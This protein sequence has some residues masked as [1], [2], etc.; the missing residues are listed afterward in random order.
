MALEIQ[1]FDGFNVRQTGFSSAEAV[2]I[3]I[4]LRFKPLDVVSSRDPLTFANSTGGAR[5]LGIEV[6]AS[7]SAKS[8]LATPATNATT[9]TGVIA[10]GGYYDMMA[11]VGG[12]RDG[13][14]RD[15][16][17]WTKPRGSGSETTATQSF[18]SDN[19]TGQTL[20]YIF[21]GGRIG[22]KLHDIFIADNVDATAA[23]AIWTAFSGGT[24]PYDI[25]EV[26]YAWDCEGANIAACYTANKG[27][28]DLITNPTWADPIASSD[29]PTGLSGG[30]VSTVRPDSTSAAGSWLT[31]AGSANLHLVLDEG[32]ADDAD[33]IISSSNPV[34]DV[35]KIGVGNFSGFTPSGFIVRYRYKKIETGGAATI[36]LRVR[37][38]EGSTSRASVTHSGISTSFVDGVM[39]LTSVEAASITDTTNLF[40]EFTA[41]P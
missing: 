2:G 29:D 26:D 37:L 18:T 16:K 36:N 7:G 3:A 4:G 24:R 21:A 38:L 15:L 10:G 17:V 30:V 33:Y 8:D 20:T 6:P 40:L 23:A 1:T 9:A 32:S 39:T 34:A 12:P 22:D 19:N 27:G 41:N 31:Q 14:S 11:W 25:T 35:C 28:I 5:A 13:S